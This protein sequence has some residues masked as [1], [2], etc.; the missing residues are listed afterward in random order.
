MKENLTHVLEKIKEVYS[1]LE[2]RQRIIIAVLIVATFFVI[3]SMISWTN[4]TEYGVLFSRLSMADAQTTITKLREL[5][6]PFKLHDDGT[7]IMIPA[8]RVTETRMFLVTNENIG[9]ANTGVGFEIFDRTTLG[10]TEFVQRTVN[11]RRATEGELAKSILTIEGVENVRIHLVLPEARIFR[12]DQNDPSAAV[13]LT[14][15]Q[16]L[17]ESQING[18]TNWIASAVEGLE[19][20]RI[21]IIDQNGRAL[22]EML[23]ETSFTVAER[24]LRVQR[25]VE[26]DYQ[27]RV[28]TMLDQI[29]DKGNSVVAVNAIINFDQIES[30]SEIWDPDGAVVR[31][32]Q[33]QSNLTTNLSDSLSVATDSQIINYEISST[34]QRRINQ[35]GDI[36]SL[37]VSVN[38]DH[39]PIRIQEGRRTIIEYEPRTPAEMADIEAIVR[40]AIGIDQNRNDRISVRNIPIDRTNEELAR[41]LMSEQAAQ[42]RWEFLFERGLVF[43]ALL[44]LIILLYTQFRKIFAKPEEEEIVEEEVIEEDFTPAYV[45]EVGPEGFYPEGDEGMPMGDSKIQM[46]FKP[47][48][49]ITVEQTEAM[50]LQEAVQ[51]FVMDHPEV[52]CRLIKSWL[53]D[54]QYGQLG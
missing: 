29:L 10:T 38:V 46:T 35:I 19:I 47:M 8:N 15:S 16:R 18:I 33:I 48:R 37:S 24:Q 44:I 1:R 25:Q 12:E 42:Q 2:L 3:I 26:R 7:T 21:S 13:V 9:V 54:K 51:K 32:E 4:K 28:Q 14:L 36:R 40:E 22:T 52:A 23:E 53:L 6:I 17:S 43:G 31:S 20:Q 5:R 50:L 30:T 11:W 49:E 41:L 34:V 39:K 45:D 27:Q